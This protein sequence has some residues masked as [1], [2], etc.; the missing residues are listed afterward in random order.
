MQGWKTI[1]KVFTGSLGSRKPCAMETDPCPSLLA[2]PPALLYKHTTMSNWHDWYEGNCAFCT[3]PGHM[4]RIK[5][6][7][8][9]NLLLVNE[10]LIQASSSYIHS[11]HLPIAVGLKSSLSNSETHK[12]SSYT[13]FAPLSYAISTYQLRIQLASTVFSLYILIHSACEVNHSLS[14]HTQAYK[15]THYLTGS[16]DH[17]S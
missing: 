9:Q 11:L 14:L 1:G 3:N 6:S 5:Y 4:Q 16:C 2:L 13:S 8:S 10:L 15:I 7:S 12:Y 17:W